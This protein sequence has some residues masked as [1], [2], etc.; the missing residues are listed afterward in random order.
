MTTTTGETVF[1]TET[2]EV[3]KPTNTLIA[4]GNYP[5]KLMSDAAVKVADGAGKIPYI[6]VSFEAD[7]TAG[8]S[9]K[10]RHVFHR[11]LLGLNPSPKDG[12]KNTNRTGGIVNF[13]KALESPLEVP[14]VTRKATLESGEEVT[15]QYLDPT[16]VKDWLVSLAGSVVTGKVK[17]QAGSGDYGP[18]NEI[19]A[20]LKG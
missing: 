12:A 11:F 9:G 3:A 1:S 16:A 5:L 13:S 2:E 15:Q 14:I 20:F 4:N 19:G 17:T 8:P 10:N 7:G 6:N 18:K